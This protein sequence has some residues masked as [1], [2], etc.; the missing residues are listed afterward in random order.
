MKKW[1]YPPSK[2][3]YAKY[4]KVYKNPKYYDQ[5]TGE[6]KWP[7]K[8]GFK[9]VPFERKTSIGEIFDRYGEPNGEFLAI[10]ETPYEQRALAPHCEK[11]NYY[12]Y[13]VVK[14]F[15][16]KEGTAAPWFGQPG[17]GKQLIGINASGNKLSVNE[18]IKAKYL[19]RVK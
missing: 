12:K 18:L 4:E 16:I 7:V 11:A 13:K 1:S 8:D 17:G 14:P 3:L 5:K 15:T 6:I 19:I 10:E 2:E 9:G